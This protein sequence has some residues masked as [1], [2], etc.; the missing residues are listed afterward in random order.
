MKKNDHNH[1][2]D[3]YEFLRDDN[4]AANNKPHGD[5]DFDVTTTAAVSCSCSCYGEQQVH[6]KFALQTESLLPWGHKTAG[7]NALRADSG[8]ARL[9]NGEPPWKPEKLPPEVHPEAISKRYSFAKIRT[10]AGIILSRNPWPLT[11]EKPRGKNRTRFLLCAIRTAEADIECV[12]LVDKS[13][14]P[15]SSRERIYV[16]RP[17][18]SMFKNRNISQFAL[19]QI[20]YETLYGSAWINASILFTSMM[21]NYAVINSYL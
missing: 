16:Y 17:R 4:F 14:L 12:L 15:V 10:T 21:N 6:Q 2:H 5:I 1:G 7:R 3:Y 13:C 18:S 9:S 19:L 8:R 20:P 11:A